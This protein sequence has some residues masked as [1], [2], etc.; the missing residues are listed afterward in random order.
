MKY[1]RLLNRLITALL[2]RRLN[3]RNYIW[4]FGILMKYQFFGANLKNG[5]KDYIKNWVDCVANVPT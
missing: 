2:A 5:V 1:Q 3:T 4:Q